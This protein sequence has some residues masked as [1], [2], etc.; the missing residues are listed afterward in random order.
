VVETPRFRRELRRLSDVK[1]EVEELR[2]ALS[3]EVIK[4]EVLEGEKADGAR[5]KVA[6]SAGKMLRVRKEKDDGDGADDDAA[7]PGTSEQ[8]PRE[9]TV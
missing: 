1:L 6:K 3:Q 5:K 2:E 4:R 9:N 7:P 8:Q